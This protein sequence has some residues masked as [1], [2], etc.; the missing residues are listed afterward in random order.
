MH[1]LSAWGKINRMRSQSFSHENSLPL[2]VIICTYDR[3]DFLNT[4]LESLTTQTLSKDKF[5]VVLIDDGSSDHTKDVSSA[6]KSALPLEHFYQ[7][8]AGLESARNHGK[9]FIPN[10]IKG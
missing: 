7:N 6:Y 4:S 9:G 3:A 8:N 5:E 10:E 2:S 1:S